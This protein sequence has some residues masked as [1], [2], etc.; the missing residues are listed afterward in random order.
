MQ[1]KKIMIIGV[2]VILAVIIGVV[3][4]ASGGKD[5]KGKTNAD[6]TSNTE[7]QNKQN[8]LLGETFNDT[9]AGVELRIPK[10]WKL[11]PKSDT[12]GSLTRIE[13]SGSSANGEVLAQQSSYDMDYV[14]RGYLEAAINLSIHSKLLHNEDVR[15][16]NKVARLVSHDVP[17]PNGQTARITEYIFYK[18]KTYYILAYTMLTSDWQA[19]AAGIEASAASFQ[20]K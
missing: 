4:V 20:I 13:Y 11:A 2:I 17:G 14:V 5:D 7:E 16:G 8:A 3:L 6:Q 15:V 1:K 10:G 12:P 18:D 9:E 19:Q